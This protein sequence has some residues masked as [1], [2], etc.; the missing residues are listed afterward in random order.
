MP[1]EVS[2]C[3]VS[4]DGKIY[5]FD[6][7]NDYIYGYNFDGTRS[8]ESDFPIQ[9]SSDPR[10]I[11]YTDG[12]I[13]AYDYIDNYIYAYNLDGTRSSQ[14]DFMH[15]VDNKEN[16]VGFAY[17]DGKFY[18]LSSSNGLGEAYV[19]DMNGDRLP[20]EDIIF[21][22]DNARPVSMEYHDGKFWVLDNEDYKVYAYNDDMIRSSSDD[23]NVELGMPITIIY[24]DDK[25]WITD[26]SNDKIES[27]MN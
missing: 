9:D 4:A 22:G 16:L 6:H 12:K 2:T 20:D 3:I 27:Y 15:T 10:G 21:D 5:V 8:L 14:D 7:L 11:V 26:V 19:Y 23:F 24:A 1:N 18:L 13:Y 17:I 25:F